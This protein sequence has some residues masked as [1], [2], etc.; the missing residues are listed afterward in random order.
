M[1]RPLP[2]KLAAVIAALT[3]LGTG[4]IP[5]AAETIG[6]ARKRRED[7]RAE[8]AAAAAQ[9][10]LLEAKAEE[11]AGALADIEASVTYQQAE[12]EGARLAVLAAEAVATERE[13]DLAATESLIVEARA[14]AAE[15]AVEAYI[16]GAQNR[17]GTSWLEADD[18][19]LGARMEA[20][21][22]D[23]RADRGD[24]FDV[25]RRLEAEQ[26]AL[27]VDA[28]EARRAADE[29]RAAMERDLLILEE[30]LAVQ[31][32]VQAEYDRRLGN[33]RAEVAALEEEDRKLTEDIRELTRQALGI[34][35]GSPGSE[36]IQGYVRP[37]KGAIGS[38]FGPRLH[39]IYRT[40][41]MHNGIDMSGSTGDPIYAAK[42]GEIIWAGPRGGYGNV[43]IIDHGEGATTVYAHQSKILVSV[44]EQVDTGEVIGAV[45][46]TGLSTGPHLHFEFRF[47]GEPKDP[48]LI[49]DA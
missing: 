18:L 41:R 27:R 38:G 22:A 16:D 19:V 34:V 5:S 20:L 32:D 1:P 3:V 10:E 21:L 35:P 12:V 47:Y 23:V 40:T 14:R 8:Q 17:Q 36:S 15:F 4:A 11:I 6:E 39:P 43:V 7:A 48:L 44:G 49:L 30:R 45:G 25:L 24:A 29:L 33:W 13:A 31:R 9:V 28:R 46:S 42:K 26:E 2:T 37:V